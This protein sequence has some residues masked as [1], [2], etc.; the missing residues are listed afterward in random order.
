MDRKHFICEF[1][2]GPRTNSIQTHN[3][4]LRYN[5]WK[6]PEIEAHG[7]AYFAK[8]TWA[9]LNLTNNVPILL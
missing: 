7:Q 6:M 4:E 8:L 3:Q 9:I 1:I 5:A 2:N